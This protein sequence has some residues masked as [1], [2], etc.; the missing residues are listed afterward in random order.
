MFSDD[1]LVLD[2]RTCV[3]VNTTACSDCVVHHL[4]AN[5]AGPIEFVPAPVVSAS[6]RA[7]QLFAKAG[8]LDDEPSF[9]SYSEFESGVVPQLA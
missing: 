1:D 8:M 3:A 5:D 2:C 4:I 6:Q 9:V 7:V